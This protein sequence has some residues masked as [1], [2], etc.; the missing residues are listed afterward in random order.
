MAAFAFLSADLSAIQSGGYPLRGRDLRQITPDI[1]WPDQPTDE[2]LAELFQGRFVRVRDTARPAQSYGDT[3]TEGPPIKLADGHWYQTWVVTP[4]D[5]VALKQQATNLANRV[6]ESKISTLEL[7]RGLAAGSPRPRTV[8]VLAKLDDVRT[9]ITAAT[10]AEE[11]GVI[12]AE[13]E[14]V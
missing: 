10:T 9:R 1:A 4:P 2:A 11:V 5:V 3:I 14:A 7:A 6:A 13:L 8:T 12:L